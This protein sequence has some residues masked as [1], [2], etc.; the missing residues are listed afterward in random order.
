MKQ[1]EELHKKYEGD[2][3]KAKEEMG[4]LFLWQMDEWIRSA[5]VMIGLLEEVLKADSWDKLTK[6]RAAKICDRV[7]EL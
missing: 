6:I 3:D 5:S 4:S 2:L 1:I 7:E